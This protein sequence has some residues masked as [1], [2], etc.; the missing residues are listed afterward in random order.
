MIATQQ[1]QSQLAKVQ[2]E[3]LDKEKQLSTLEDKNYDMYMVMVVLEHELEQQQ[4]ELNQK[5]ACMCN[6]CNSDEHVLFRC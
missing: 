4:K 6:I 2:Q 5:G 1:L 3:S